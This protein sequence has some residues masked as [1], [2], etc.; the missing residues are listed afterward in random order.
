MCPV[1]AAY[2][3]ETC[4]PPQNALLHAAIPIPF[5]VAV[6]VCWGQATAAK[7]I[8]T[9]NKVTTATFFECQYKMGLEGAPTPGGG[10]P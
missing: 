5:S 8:S 6:A 4:L 1:P 7:S 3:S 9:S 2:L 10:R